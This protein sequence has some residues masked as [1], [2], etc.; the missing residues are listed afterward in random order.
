MAHRKILTAAF[1]VLVGV[2]LCG[3]SFAQGARNDGQ[4]TMTVV[5]ENQRPEDIVNQ[6]G[7]PANAAQ[8]GV[9]NAQQGQDT[10]DRTQRRERG[11]HRER[12]RDARHGG[13][14]DQA[15]DRDHLRDQMRDQ[16]RDQV[17]DQVSDQIRDQVRDQLHDQT[18]DPAAQQD[19]LQQHRQS[20]GNR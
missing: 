1:A 18:G 14:T 5:D 16:M 7:L 15:G 6:I 20:G 17:S 8:T 2:A 9:E 19:R 13:A 10:A 11:M 3:S 4:D 12:A